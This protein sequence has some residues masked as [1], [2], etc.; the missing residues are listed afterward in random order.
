MAT[1]FTRSPFFPCCSSSD[2]GYCQPSFFLHLYAVT[3]KIKF[4]MPTLS[5]INML[6]YDEDINIKRITN[7]VQYDDNMKNMYLRFNMSIHHLFLTEL[8]YVLRVLFVI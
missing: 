5:K 7:T 3:L 6:S 1:F 4:E 2:D 8:D